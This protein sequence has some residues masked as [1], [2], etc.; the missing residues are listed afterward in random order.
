GCSSRATAAGTSSPA[1]RRRASRY[2]TRGSATSRTRRRPTCS[3]ARSTF[4]S[5]PATCCMRSG[6]T[7]DDRSSI[8]Q[9]RQPF[10]ETGLR[11]AARRRVRARRPWHGGGSKS[12]L[13]VAPQV[14]AEERQHTLLEALLDAVDVIAFVRLERMLDAVAGHRLAQRAVRADQPVLLADVEH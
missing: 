3:T 13:L 2:G 1:I 11:T 5:R 9:V 6:C 8:E 14:P 10:S 4:S 12:S 7:A